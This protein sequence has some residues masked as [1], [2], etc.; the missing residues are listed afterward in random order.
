MKLQYIFP[1]CN[2]TNNFEFDFF[3]GVIKI[4]GIVDRRP[5]FG[6]LAGLLKTLGW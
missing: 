4:E 1:S 6:R 3:G 2:A 5:N